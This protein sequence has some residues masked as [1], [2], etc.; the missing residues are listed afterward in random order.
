MPITGH[1]LADFSSFQTAVR[2]AEVRLKSFE[3]GSG[4]V[5]TS[6]T[7]MANSL[8]GTSLIQSATL[9]AEAVERVGGVSALTSQELGRVGAKA[10]EAT[11]KMRRMGIE[12]PPGLQR[13][14]DAA[15]AA[16]RPTGFLETKMIALGAAVG[17]FAA[18]LASRAVSS[19]VAFGREAFASA[20]HIVD[21]ANKT[22]LGTTAIQR[23]QFV[24]EQTGTSVDAFT[25]AAFKLGVNLSGGSTSVRA[26][27]EATGLAFE[28]LRQMR[29]DQQFE[30]II[31]ALGRMDNQ[32]ERNRAGVALFGKQFSEIASSVQEGYSQIADGAT[33]ATTAQLQALD[34]A[35]DRWDAWLRNVQTSVS[36]FL[37]QT[38]LIQDALRQVQQERGPAAQRGLRPE[39]L[40]EAQRRVQLGLIGARREDIALTNTATVAEESYVAQLAKVRAELAALTPAQ[41][42]EIEAATALGVKQEELETKYHLTEGALRILSATTVDATAKTA[43]AATTND[44]LARAYERVLSE[45]RNAQG[46][47]LFNYDVELRRLTEM[48]INMDGVLVG[49]K[50]IHEEMLLP[51]NRLTDKDFI[52]TGPSGLQ[53]MWKEEESAF[54]RHQDALVTGAGQLFTILGLKNKKFAIAGAIINT[55]QAI[56]K[57]LASAPW[58]WNLA[59]AAGAAAAGWAQVSHIRGSEAGGFQRGT[60][61]LDF[62]SFG[63]RSMAELHGEE[64]VIPRGGGH[65]LAGEIAAALTTRQPPAPVLNITIP[66]Q[67]W[68]G[69]DVVRQVREKALPVIIDA[70]RF[71]WDDFRTDFGKANA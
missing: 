7:R 26:A 21:L 13:I 14:A 61:N 42:R 54:K 52:P 3:T 12:V 70:L 64:A 27:V 59:L 67:A 41:R 63:S 5:A 47:F 49:L 44:T 9:M 34:R 39:D 11:D 22:G 37:G 57:S 68:D 43:K 18:N 32:Q 19:L 56:A 16:Q 62:Q 29:P 58:P 69:V 28:T 15:N 30:A 20:G 66:I 1:F 60:R 55:Y 71:N 8:S 51:S 2:D 48:R 35:S 33:V 4:K 53:K 36:A 40:L 10:N 50:S 24:A 65:V 45:A 31:A 25:T 23:M 46:L 6:L 17:T 38:L